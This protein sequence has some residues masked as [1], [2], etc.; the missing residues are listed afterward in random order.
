MND[1]KRAKYNADSECPHHE[2]D[3]PIHNVMSM[4]NSCMPYS[5]ELMY[6]VSRLLNL[7]Y[8]KGERT[9]GRP[10]IVSIN[11][12]NYGKPTMAILEWQGSGPWCRIVMDLHLRLS[13]GSL[14]NTTVF[15]IA[16]RDMRK[17]VYAVEAYNLIVRY[18]EKVGLLET[19]EW[20]KGDQLAYAVGNFRNGAFTD[21]QLCDFIMGHKSI[22][23]IQQESD[24]AMDAYLEAHWK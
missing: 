5:I 1:N 10:L 23:Q 17:R 20:D 18:L 14:Y 9:S 15:M 13:W 21:K 4:H 22:D 24:D 16:G 12:A 8:H 19:E 2:D 11:R 7:D 3:H 6:E